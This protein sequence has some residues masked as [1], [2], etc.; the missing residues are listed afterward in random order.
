MEGAIVSRN[1]GN[2]KRAGMQ[3]LSRFDLYNAWRPA[4]LHRIGTNLASTN[5]NRG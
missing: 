3:Q 1:V 4:L 2:G 5:L